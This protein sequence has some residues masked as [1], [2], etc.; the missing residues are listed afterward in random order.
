MFVAFRRFMEMFVIRRFLFLFSSFFP[1]VRC[2]RT[3]KL[4][5]NADRALIF[6]RT[7][8]SRQAAG[9]MLGGDGRA[10]RGAGG[11]SHVPAATNYRFHD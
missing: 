2:T 7:D 11:R 10:G 5:A 6:E 3:S 8:W 9:R 1:T 4:S